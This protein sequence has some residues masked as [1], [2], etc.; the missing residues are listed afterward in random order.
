MSKYACYVKFTAR[1]GQRDALVALLL[2][3]AAQVDAAPGCHIYLINTVH[4]DP[5]VVWVT[6]LWDSQ[7]DAE[8]QLRQ[9][10]AR[11][12]IQQVI[13]LLACSPDRTI[14]E[15]VGGKGLA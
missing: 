5:N 12:R 1:P 7:A 4:E 2:E 9:E 14:L 15:P 6:E 3:A 10:G 11:E 13:A 8:A